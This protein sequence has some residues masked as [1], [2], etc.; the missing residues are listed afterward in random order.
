MQFSLDNVLMVL[1]I[2]LTVFSW[3]APALV[4]ALNEKK[5]V[6]LA[7][8][9]EAGGRLAAQIAVDLRSVPP[10]MSFADAKARMVTEAVN[11]LRSPE[12][13]GQTIA[14]LGGTDAG[15]RNIIEGELSKLQLVAPALPA[16]AEGLTGVYPGVSVARLTENG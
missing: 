8:V 3:G 14:K 12:L 16:V 13:F 1:G 11:R 10:G 6:R 4:R 7:S 5:A 2:A 15:V 9:V